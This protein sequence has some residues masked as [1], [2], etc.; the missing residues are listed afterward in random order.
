MTES[1][2]IIDQVDHWAS[3]TVLITKV[4]YISESLRCWAGVD[5]TRHYPRAHRQDHHTIDRPEIKGVK[6]GSVW[7]TTLK[8][9]ELGIVNQTDIETIVYQRQHCQKDD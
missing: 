7:R 4:A 3:I 2:E 6:K 9:P 1:K 8:G 5:D